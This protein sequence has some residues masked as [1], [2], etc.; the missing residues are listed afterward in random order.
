[1]KGFGTNGGTFHASDA[2]IF[3]KQHLLF[4]FFAL[5]IMT[6]DATEWT[7]LQKHHSANSR[8]VV[9]GKSLNIKYRTFHGLSFPSKS[10]ILILS[11]VF[12]FF[13]WI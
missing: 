12:S 6:P 2:F 1:M 13:K 4:P 5:G 11:P 8:T 9:K 3:V 7:A 10:S